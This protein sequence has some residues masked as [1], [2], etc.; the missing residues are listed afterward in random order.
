MRLEVWA[1]SVLISP[2]PTTSTRRPLSSP[3]IF[4]ARSTA[5]KLTDTAP[6]PRAGLGP[7]AFADGEGPVEQLVQHGPVAVTFRGSLNASF[8]CPRICGSP[9]TIESRPAATRNRCRAASLS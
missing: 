2:A 5:A 7:H 3:K 6:S 8:T 1:V 4:R 9:T